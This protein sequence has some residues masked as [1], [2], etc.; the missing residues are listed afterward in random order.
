MFSF[1]LVTPPGCEP[2]TLAEA[3]A[4]ARIDSSADDVLITSLIAAARQWIEKT[5]G[6]ALI[7]QTWQLAIDRFASVDTCGG[8]DGFRALKLPRAPLQSVT[9][10]A[11]YDDAD[12]ATIWPAANYFVDT[13]HEPGRIA[14]RN[15]AVWPAPTRDVNSIIITYVAGY[16]SSA[17]SVPEAIKLALKQLVAHWYEHRGDAAV[18]SA[19]RGA[20]VAAVLPVPMVIQALLDPYRIRYS[21][22]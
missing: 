10:I 17:A 16:G 20:N 14:L 19:S 8:I 13:A 15:G 18:S 7:N 22:I 11:S 4:H 2:V 9:S 12:N 5:T 1:S 6:R 3:K 21:G